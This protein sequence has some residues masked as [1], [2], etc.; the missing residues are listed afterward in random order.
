MIAM[1]EV[2]SG[3]GWKPTYNHIYLFDGSKAVAYIPNGKTEAIYFKNPMKIH[4]VR[5]KFVELKQNPFKNT[6]QSNLIR[7]VG[8]KGNVYHVDPDLKTCTC[9]GFTFRGRCK[10]VDSLYSAA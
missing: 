9:S 1:Q 5:R 10:H 3:S 4:R 7:I 6:V 2:T 8:S